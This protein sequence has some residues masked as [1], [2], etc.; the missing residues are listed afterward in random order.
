MEIVASTAIQFRF[1]IKVESDSEQQAYY[2]MDKKT[3]HNK[4]RR[5]LL[6]L[7]NCKEKAAAAVATAEKKKKTAA[8]AEEKKTKRA[9]AARKRGSI[10]K[11]CPTKRCLKFRQQLLI[12]RN[13]DLN[14]ISVLS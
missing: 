7:P 6:Q 2:A 13:Q 4:V 14:A 12:Y 10:R 9:T 1:L 5:S 3:A 8:V 11:R